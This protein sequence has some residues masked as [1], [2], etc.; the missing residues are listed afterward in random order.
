MGITYLGKC[1]YLPN[2]TSFW[3]KKIY[4]HSFGPFFAKMVFHIFEILLHFPKNSN[5]KLPVLVWHMFDWEH[6]TMS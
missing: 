4:F 3:K 5:A 2:H 6:L 1:L